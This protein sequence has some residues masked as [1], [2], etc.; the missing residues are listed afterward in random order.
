MEIKYAYLVSETKKQLVIES[1]TCCAKILLHNQIWGCLWILMQP[2]T[3]LASTDIHTELMQ[4]RSFLDHWSASYFQILLF[5]LESN[6][7]LLFSRI[8]ENNLRKIGGNCTN[9]FMLDEARGNTKGREKP[10]SSSF[11]L[12]LYLSLGMWKGRRGER[13]MQEMRK[14]GVALTGF[15]LKNISLHHPISHPS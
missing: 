14:R 2:H 11:S 9:T 13:R 10:F 1:P 8:E 7:L 3:C 4:I 5:G 6:L 15:C 12:Y